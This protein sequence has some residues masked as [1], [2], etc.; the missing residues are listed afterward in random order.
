MLRTADSQISE[1]NYL[2][3]QRQKEVEAIDKH[4]A[5]VRSEELKL[6]V[7]FFTILSI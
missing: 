6:K 2:L 5:K 4:I 3:V 1:L 7:C